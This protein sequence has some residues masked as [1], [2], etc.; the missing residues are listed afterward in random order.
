[1]L[2]ADELESSLHPNLVAHLVGLFQD[3]TTN[4]RKAQLIFNS[5]EASLLGNSVSDRTLGR[6]QVW[7]SEKLPDGATR[8][9]PLSD[10]NPRKEEAVGRRYLAGR[11]GATPIIASEEF[12]EIAD[13][14]SAGV[15]E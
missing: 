3:P 1:V 8:L 7:F 10:L 15:D 5:H 9:Y 12:A 6:D 14:I 4:P 13:L 2:L 11:Y